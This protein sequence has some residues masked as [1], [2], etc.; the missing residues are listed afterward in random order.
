MSGRSRGQQRISYD[1]Q[2]GRYPRRGWHS[3]NGPCKAP[4]KLGTQ[5]RRPSHHV[6]S[7]ARHWRASQQG[8]PHLTQCRCRWSRLER[9]AAWGPGWRA[10]GEREPM[11]A[12]T[13]EPHLAEPQT[14]NPHAG[15]RHKRQRAKAR[16]YPA[17]GRIRRTPARACCGCG[18]RAG[19]WHGSISCSCGYCLSL[20]ICQFARSL[21]CRLIL[22]VWRGPLGRVGLHAVLATCCCLCDSPAGPAHR[23]PPPELTLGPRKPKKVRKALRVWHTCARCA[24]SRVAPSLHDQTRRSGS[25]RETQPPQPTHVHQ[26]S[27]GAD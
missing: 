7:W 23:G 20:R 2:C 11:E 12:R 4:N 8:R 5:S 22:G 3:S 27:R 6:F 18:W 9:D 10:N 24:D 21:G 25:W 1:V 19:A 17:L 16:F 13:N 15:M 26:Q 14:S